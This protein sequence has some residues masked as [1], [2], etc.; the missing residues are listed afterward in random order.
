MLTECIPFC[1]CDKIV[2]GFFS[3]TACRTASPCIFA[4]PI[5]VAKSICLRCYLFPCFCSSSNSAKFLRLFLMMLPQYALREWKYFID[6]LQVLRIVLFKP[7][8]TV[9]IKPDSA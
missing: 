9:E 4:S 6:F 2:T 5:S 3:S 1:S 7:Q 8:H